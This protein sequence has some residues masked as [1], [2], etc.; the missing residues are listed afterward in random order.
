MY[1]K[2]YNVNEIIFSEGDI[3]KAIFFINDGEV[4]IIRKD[5]KGREMVLTK[6]TAGDFFGEMALLEELPRSAAARVSKEGTLYFIYKVR[7]DSYIQKDPANGLIIYKN[8][9]KIL[10]SRLRRTSEQI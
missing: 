8:L 6:L 5:S 9:M 4:E 7:F 10:S 2:K 1:S 3:G